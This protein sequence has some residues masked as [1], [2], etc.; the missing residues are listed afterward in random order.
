MNFLT[1]GSKNDFKEVKNLIIN[2]FRSELMVILLMAE[3]LM[4]LIILL[5]TLMLI[6]FISSIE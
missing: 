1:I 2:D 6:Y 5:K 3:N 4:V